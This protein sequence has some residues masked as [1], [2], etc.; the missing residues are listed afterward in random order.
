[1]LLSEGAELLTMHHEPWKP[2]EHVPF[3]LKRSWAG[4]GEDG[5]GTKITL[6]I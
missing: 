2:E 3:S 1:M 5:K 6:L 4:M